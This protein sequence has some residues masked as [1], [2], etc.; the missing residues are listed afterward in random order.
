MRKHL[1]LSL[2]VLTLAACETGPEFKYA[3]YWQRAD[4]SSALYLRGP[5][6]QQTLH[7]HM[8]QCVAEVNELHRLGSIRR[9]VPADLNESN[10]HGLKNYDTP[11]RDGYKYAE[12]FDYADFET[13]MRHHGWERVE[14]LPYDRAQEARQTWTD[15]IRPNTKPDYLEPEE[16]HIEH[17]ER[18]PY[19]TLN[20]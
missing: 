20:D 8:S 9:A 5:K 2:S 12:Y 14:H 7:Q 4:A 10:P 13:C 18:D 11:E 15:T 1:I 6:A 16:P 3:Q 17:R 19:N